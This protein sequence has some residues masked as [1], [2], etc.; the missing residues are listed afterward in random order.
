VH[1]RIILL[2][3]NFL[4]SL[5]LYLFQFILLFSLTLLKIPYN[6]GLMLNLSQF[7]S[8]YSNEILTNIL[9]IQ[10]HYSSIIRFNVIPTMIYQ[11]S[12]HIKI[13]ITKVYFHNFINELKH[14]C[15]LTLVNNSCK[16]I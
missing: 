3:F 12:H 7:S 1:F 13:N 8:F 6:R 10:I 11:N 9:N 16:Y 4:E 14:Q 2:V 15:S 5:F